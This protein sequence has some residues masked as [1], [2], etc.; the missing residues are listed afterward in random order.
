VRAQLGTEGPLDGA[1]SAEAW[2]RGLARDPGAAWTFEDTAVAYVHRLFLDRDADPDAGLARPAQ[3]APQDV[4]GDHARL[5]EHE[6]AALAHVFQRAFAQWRASSSACRGALVLSAASTAPGAGWGVLDVTGRPTAAWYGMR[7]ACAPVALSFLPAGGDGLALHVFNDAPQPL[8]GTV[9]LTVATVR[10]G[11]QPPLELPVHVPAHGE[12]TLRADLAD[13]AFRDLD[14]AY[15]FGQREYDAVSAV[16]LDASGRA[17]ARDAHLT[18]GP[19]RNEPGDP[20]LTARWEG[21]TGGSWRVAVTATG[22]ARFVALDLPATGGF[23]SGEAVAE[24]GYVHVLPGETVCLPVSGA[25]T[26]SVRRE[27]RV[28]ALDA[29]PVGVAGA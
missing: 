23:S 4:L 25:V 21:A 28:R 15:G 12:L 1:E 24:D 29:D 5:L 7:R 10:G 2:R 8:H 3:P 27:T 22:L 9:W 19:R 17:L 11:S 18:G 26:D 13:G 14:H 16:L 6:R 20:G